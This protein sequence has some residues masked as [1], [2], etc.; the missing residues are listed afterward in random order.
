MEDALVD[1]VVR[2]MHTEIHHFK[3]RWSHSGNWLAWAYI[4][5]LSM[6]GSND[7]VDDGDTVTWTSTSGE[8]LTML[9]LSR[10]SR[11]WV[12]KSDYWYYQA[13]FARSTWWVSDCV[14]LFHH[15]RRVGFQ[16][17]T[18]FHFL[19][20]LKWGK[21]QDWLSADIRRILNPCEVVTQCWQRR[22]LCRTAVPTISPRSPRIIF[23]AC[24]EESNAAAMGFSCGQ[25]CEYIW[26]WK[27]GL[28]STQR[29]RSLATYNNLLP[30]LLPT[31]T[32][33]HLS[34]FS[35]NFSLLTTEGVFDFEDLNYFGMRERLSIHEIFFG[36]RGEVNLWY[37]DEFPCLLVINS[38]RRTRPF[39]S[40][41]ERTRRERNDMY[42]V[43]AC[44]SRGYYLD[45]DFQLKFNQNRNNTRSVWLKR[46]SLQENNFMAYC[47]SGAMKR[48]R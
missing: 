4:S 15:I 10:K 5:G 34:R 40:S 31:T 32:L 42:R 46:R 33:R 17:L 8:A 27:D 23:A 43:A 22:W 18:L 35:R 2:N 28:R 13:G 30:S 6:V 24:S 11:S 39:L 3:Y 44:I 45:V 29:K 19:A 20:L 41:R 21:L 48:E 25:L 38:E 47:T 14:C 16:L 12:A 36:C 9:S 37:L 1:I 7:K 26:F